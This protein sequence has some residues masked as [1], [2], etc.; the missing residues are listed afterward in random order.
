MPIGSLLALYFIIWWLTLFAVLPF[1]VRSQQETGEV[2]TGSDPGA[3][4]SVRIG[5]VMLINSVVAA[6]VLAAFWTV[7]VENWFGLAIVD[8]LNR[9]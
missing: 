5:R 2:V 3:P 1:G 8:E 4:A 6:L 9:R 7:Y